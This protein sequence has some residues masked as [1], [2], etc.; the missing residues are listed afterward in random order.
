VRSKRALLD[1]YYD[2]VYKKTQSDLAY[3]N[4]EIGDVISKYS[5]AEDIEKRMF[6][7]SIN[8]NNV[9]DL[10]SNRL[11]KHTQKNIDL[12]KCLKCIFT[13]ILRFFFYLKE[14]NNYHADFYFFISNQKFIRFFNSLNADFRQRGF[15]T[16]FIFWDK[17]DIPAGF[18]EQIIVVK[19]AI[20]NFFSKLYYQ[21]HQFTSQVDR[22]MTI[23]KKLRGKKLFIPEG[24][25]S[26]MHIAAKIGRKYHFETVCLQWGFFGKSATKVGWRDMPYTKFL[27]WGEFFKKAFQEYN[28]NLPIVISG[29]PNLRIENQ[30]TQ[31]KKYI[32]VAVQKEMGDHIT[33]KDVRFF[34]ESIYQIID[35]IPTRQFVIRTHPDLPFHR[36][37]VKPKEGL[38]NLKIHDYQEFTLNESLSGAQV[39]IAISSA[40]VIESLTSD[41]YPIYIKSNSLPM[42]L[43]DTI[44]ENS[45]TKHVFTFSE[46]KS[47]LIQLEYHT[48][49]PR[50]IEMKKSFY[51]KNQ[52]IENILA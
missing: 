13:D 7:E 40:T 28:P 38:K 2:S 27:V 39:C 17:S 33:D 19:P 30:Y 8:E 36:L 1:F 6:I 41:C 20:P 23:G 12:I 21:H 51:S 37:P 47:F 44:E 34:L 50:I 29:H 16:A 4:I 49:L 14:K 18:N 11:K 32:L 45:E 3:K 35:D 26:S 24:C 43:Y 48:L 42:Q 9:R 46:L 10:I 5:I 31:E 15:S 52:V 25:I 22:F